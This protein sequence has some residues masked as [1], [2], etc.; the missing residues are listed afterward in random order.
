MAGRDKNKE[1][2][3]RR[4][5]GKE[6]RAGEPQVGIFWLVRGKLVFDATPLSAAEVHLHFR[7]H[8]GDHVR[9]W[10]K[11]RQE[12]TVPMEMEYEEPPRGRVAYDNIDQ[13]FTLLADKCIIKEKVVV[14]EII[15]KLNL[16]AGTATAT[17]QHYRCHAC[18]CGTTDDED[19]ED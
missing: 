3:G 1:S 2:T 13:R 15:S 10:D 5:A 19:G 16:P 18:M 11:L 14:R 8:P 7:I 4:G 12:K 17:D 9:I 6:K